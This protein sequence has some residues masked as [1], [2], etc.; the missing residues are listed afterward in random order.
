[1]KLTVLS[2]IVSFCAI[3][4]VAFGQCP[5]GD[6]TGD[7][8]INSGSSPCTISS[9]LTITGDITITNSGSLIVSSGVML[10]VM[11]TITLKNGSSITATGANVNAETFSDGS[12]TNT[13]TGGTYTVG[14]FTMSG[15]GSTTISGI[16]VTA[17]NQIVLDDVP[18]VTNSNFDA[19]TFF[20]M[21]S[22]SPDYNFNN[23]N[24]T[25]G[26][27]ADI[28]D[29]S[30]TNST[31]NVGDAL[32]IS[33]GNTT[34][35]NSTINTG[36]TNVGTN[37]ADALLFNG[38]GVLTLNNDTQMNVRGSVVNNEWYVDNS[39][40]IVTGDFDNQGSEILEV[41]NNGTFNV[42]GDF[43]NTGSGNVS[44][45]DG[46]LV[47]VD[48][49]YD[50]SGGGSTDVDGG[51]FSVGGTYSGGGATGDTGDCASGGGGCCG[52][53]CSTLPVSL[54]NFTHE[55]NNNSVRIKWSTASELNNDFF[56]IERS[57]DG[58]NFEELAVVEGQGTIDD[59]TNYSLIDELRQTTDFV[60]YRLSQT[61]FDGTH[62]TLG[63]ITVSEGFSIN[64]FKLYP[65]PVEAGGKLDLS[66]LPMN[67]KWSIYSLSGNLLESGQLDQSK[68][69][70]IQGLRSGTYIFNIKAGKLSQR[71]T[72]IVE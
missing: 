66:Q 11:G 8:T 38:G 43:N 42:Q 61:D 46:G 47:V 64:D 4:G 12:N 34:F 13:I 5:S 41:R 17:T 48:G 27:T 15:G 44:A 20:Q 24:I 53:G 50:N 59:V 36:T 16:D 18:N 25:A 57:F 3:G 14:S 32:S 71:K 26:T 62:E 51:T 56:T 2:F 37:D 7:L 58:L 55:L 31:L 45:D 9:D 65:N 72:L 33:S 52:A 6:V 10:T 39:D 60:Y 54:I 28:Q 22:G 49:N 70:A 68:E 35:D 69:V 63:I 29:V 67:A 23:V 30:F 1:M 19:G 40:V 21:N